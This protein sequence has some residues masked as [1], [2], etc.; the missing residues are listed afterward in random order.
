MSLLMDA[1]R[2]AEAEKKLAAARA[3]GLALDTAATTDELRLEPLETS[4][5]RPIRALADDTLYDQQA[6]P[7]RQQVPRAST[8][9]DAPPAGPDPD[10]SP[11]LTARVGPG[12]AAR[13]TIVTAQ[14]V[15]DATR[16]GG[17][18]R[19]LIG[20]IALTV[21]IAAGL[22][23]VGIYAY[24]QTP[25]TRSIPSPRVA[26]QLEPAA[27]RP[28][29]ALPA[30]VITDRMITPVTGASPALPDTPLVAAPPAAPVKV[31]PEP[32]P[33]QN[34]TAAAVATAV[35]PPAPAVAAP[36]QRALGAAIPKDAEIA[37][38]EVRIAKRASGSVAPDAVT[39]AYAAFQLGQFATAQRLYQDALARDP[40]RLD[41]Q[42]GLAAI[43]MRDSRLTDAHRLY[44]EVLKREPR[45]P[46]ASAALFMIEGGNGN[47]ITE[48]RLKLLAD[49]D[50]DSPYLR[51]ALGNLY[52]RQRRWA[53]AQEAYFV[54]FARTPANADYAYNL[55]V[56]LD[57]L[58]QRPAALQ[59]YRKALELKQA[60]SGAFDVTRAAARVA[61][62]AGAP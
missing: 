33:V 21:L 20:V 52:A 2:R 35:P 57:Q 31:G 17:L 23:A 18:P 3:S 46:V 4:T 38:G 40:E 1:L 39:H 5:E 41:A 16:G 54:A 19:A 32:E 22:T 8:A 51:F 15:F 30:P 28:V 6:A 9:R 59:Y 47:D 25:H 58:G 61:A 62:L 27:A 56:S 55:A 11:F 29:P 60:G 37:S 43:A 53:D 34:P 50:A 42:L 7:T 44:L 48:A 26:A 12:S 13:P 49:N 45:H 14:T 24:R 36:L 10:I